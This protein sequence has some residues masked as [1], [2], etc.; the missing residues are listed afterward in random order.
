M[1]IFCLVAVLA[2]AAPLRF[3]GSCAHHTLHGVIE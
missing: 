3:L 2:A 1:P